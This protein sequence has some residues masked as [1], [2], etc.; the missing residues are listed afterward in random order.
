MSLNILHITPDFNY[1]CGR[2]YYVYQ[3]I[4]H[5]NKKNN[6]FLITNGGDSLERLEKLNIN[7][8]IIKSLKS[9]NPILLAKNI[10][11]IKNFIDSY[12]I[13]IIHTHHR[14]C[15]LI[16]IQA[17]KLIKHN[18]T[19]TVLTA[20]SLVKRKYNV[21]YK[22]DKIIA[23]SNCVK[24]MLIKKFKV[25]ENKI[26]LIPNFTDT[27]ELRKTN[28]RVPLKKGKFYNILAVGRFHAEKNFELLLKALNILQD[29]KIQLIL[30]GEGENL[31]VYKKYI[32]SYKLNAEIIPP[33][34]SL[35]QF[36]SIADL[37]V[38]PSIRDP[39]PNFMLQSGLH[40]KPFIGSNVDGIAEL[41]KS[42]KNGLI[43]E[44]QNE[45]DLAEK[46]KFMMRNRNLAK[47]YAV[48][49]HYDVIKNYTQKNVIP[50]ISRIYNELV[51]S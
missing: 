41:I 28:K 24:K 36:F 3:I 48:K 23:V 30:I 2:S 32:N 44:S 29:K 43:F 15:E 50:K 40:K 6:V 38:L 7:Y 47:K 37:C 46:I 31:F 19:N 45:K 12:K 1:A 27:D 20:L 34:K 11:K 26:L 10:R 33:Q 18:K 4:K 14:Y 42:K 39:F 35:T 22:S 49:L 9:K 25:D 17:A 5:F 13:D 16:A 51:K 8:E 21:E